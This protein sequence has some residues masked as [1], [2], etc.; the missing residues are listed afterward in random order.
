MMAAQQLRPFPAPSPPPGA[1]WESHFIS[2]IKNPFCAVNNRW[3]EPWEAGRTGSW[4]GETFSMV[5][6]ILQHSWWGKWTG[7]VGWSQGASPR[8]EAGLRG[9]GLSSRQKQRHRLS[10]YI[11]ARW[12]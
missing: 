8:A 12:V 1:T 7:G 4:L 2:Q 3:D 6:Q 9:S 10:P 11:Q 5:R